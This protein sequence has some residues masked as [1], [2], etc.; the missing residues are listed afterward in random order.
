[1]STAL[2]A[3][4]YFGTYAG[5]PDITEERR[6]NAEDL[7][8]RVNALLERAAGDGVALAINPRTGS[9]VSGETNGGFRPQDCP[10]GAPRSTHKE[11]RGVDIYDPRRE[12]ARWCYREHEWLRQLGLS[13][14][15]A[16]WTPG[17]VHL[18]SRP[19]GLAGSP[20]RLDFVPDSSPARAP[21]LR[22]QVAWWHER[23]TVA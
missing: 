15:D 23:G 19:P 10:I 2:T 22:E 6:R 8:I 3:A 20:W 4:E 12:L 17:W 14:E 9:A 5:H 18:Q 11:A 1:M 7:L 16:R 21:A 13:M